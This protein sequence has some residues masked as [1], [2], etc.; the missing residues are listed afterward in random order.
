MTAKPELVKLD[1]TQLD[2]LEE[3]LVGSC[4]SLNGG[5]A[6]LGLEYDQLDASSFDAIDARMFLCDKCGWWY[7]E[8]DN[9]GTVTCYECY[10][11]THDDDILD[12]DD[13]LDY[14]DEFD[15]DEEHDDV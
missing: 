15:P 9:A 4:N 6:T 2:A 5:L 7:K 14:P 12:E 11:M 10:S 1:K 8:D 13:L 3:Y